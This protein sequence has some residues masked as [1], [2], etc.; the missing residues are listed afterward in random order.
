MAGVTAQRSTVT[1]GKS[2]LAQDVAVRRLE[3]TPAN[4]EKL[5]NEASKDRKPSAVVDLG[6]DVVLLSS[7]YLATE[8]KIANSSGPLLKAGRSVSV[9]GVEGK[10]L[11]TDDG[12]AEIDASKV[13][14]AVLD[15]G[16]DMDHPAFEGRIVKPFDATT[17][18]KDVTDTQGHGTHVAGIIA[19]E[20]GVKDGAGGVARDAQI[21]PVK[22]FGKSGKA[23]PK[24]VAEGIRYAADNGAKIINMSLGAT[25]EAMKKAGLLDQLPEFKEAIAY[26]QSKGVVVIAAS[27]NDGKD[28]I[29]T[30]YPASLPDVLT[31]GAV[32]YS[33]KRAPFS[34]G[35]AELELTAPG[36]DILSAIPGEGATYKKLQGTS[37]AAP[38]VAGAAAL[39]IAQNPD[40]TAEQVMEHLTRAVDDRGK[41]GKD[42]AYGHGEINLFKAAFGENLPAQPAPQPKRS[43]GEKIAEFFGAN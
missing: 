8:S 4:R 38:Y 6:K 18:G 33:H 9:D 39:V 30:Y 35:G 31:V 13:I 34:N 22:V 10:V 36:V 23:E 21:M 28:D 2:G 12:F 19:G 43:F 1:W 26:A 29:S 27:G 16:I 25:E 14:V 24:H 41:A 3:D 5:M 20:W 42:I 40:W 17:G 11:S 32:N 37:M 15:T 7:A